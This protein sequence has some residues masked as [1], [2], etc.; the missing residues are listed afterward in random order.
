MIDPIRSIVPLPGLPGGLPELE[1]LF[2]RDNMLESGRAL[3]REAFTTDPKRRVGGGSRN[4]RVR[5]AS[6]KMGCVIQCESR[7]VER[8]FV[9]LCEHDP[10]IRLYL[11]QPIV[12]QIRTLPSE[13][14]ARTFY[15][16]LDY[17][18]YHEDHG[19]ML[20]ECKPEKKLE[21]QAR[22]VRDGD[23]WRYPALERAVAD[24]GL[25]VWVYSSEE[26]NSVWL[27]NVGWLADYVGADCPDRAL[28]DQL[29][30]RVRKVRSIRVSM[31]LELLGD[32]TEALWWLVANNHLAGDLESEL[33]HDRDWAWVHD[34]P[35]RAIAWR[36]ARTESDLARASLASRPNVVR[37]EPDARLIWD[38]VPWRVLNR[39][40]DKVTLQREDSTD[41]VVLLRIADV[42][43]LL[44]RGALHAQDEDRLDAIR[45]AREARVLRASPRELRA[46]RTRYEAFAHFKR[47]GEPPTGVSSKSIQ[48]YADS[49][50]R[51]RRL[52]LSAFVGLISQRGRPR[53]IDRLAPALRAAI[54][55]AVDAYRNDPG[56]GSKTAAYATLVDKWSHPYLEAPS[57]DTL[58]RAI[59]AIPRSELARGRRGRREVIRLEGPAPALDY[60]TPPHGDRVWAVGEIDHTPLD[61][62]LVSSVTGAVLG[63]AYLSVLIDAFTRMPLAFVLRFGAPRRYPVLELLHECV[64]RHGRVPDNIV[65][66]GGPEFSSN[67]VE[68]AFAVLEI[69]KIERAT[70]R[71]KQGAVIE[72]M[73]GIANE[74]MT[75]QL[76]GNTEPNTLGRGLSASHRPSR[77]A[78]WTL[79]KACQACEKFFFETCP[80]LQ[81]GSLGTTPRE[82]FEH[83][84]AVAGERVAKHVFFDLALRAL[85]A[86]TPKTGGPTRKVDGSRG[87]F[88]EY[89]SYWHPLFNRRDVDGISVDVKVFPDDCG[90][91]LAVVHGELRRCQLSDGGYDFAGRSRRQIEMAVAVL[92][93]QHR[94]GRSRAAR[95]ANAEIIGAFLSHLGDTEAE[96]AIKVQNLRDQENAIA[97]ASAPLAPD[98]PQLRLAAVDGK[99]VGSS[100][101]VVHPSERSASQP[102]S[103]ELPE[104]I[105]F[106]GLEA[107][108]ED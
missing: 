101:V 7:T 90:E 98:A 30:E 44:K 23:S 81:H 1:A 5:F 19:W 57:Y 34:T 40:A 16:T 95:R 88:V 43:T 108:D 26:I 21:K 97:A 37:I 106:D 51:G 69:S 13:G 64:R 27:R 84:M 105:D 68:M 62:S 87:V 86:E 17:I 54:D 73:F 78:A 47:T 4:T 31:L 33:I 91:V 22:F 46:A 48:R 76:R 71:P 75:H 18:V 74:R 60:A 39:G 24:L 70:G 50:E 41:K 45:A 53:G 96:C 66:D 83:S 107:L 29:L 72:R 52:Y 77:F 93:E 67:D 8:A 14:S 11:C 80:A 6:R 58:R 61:L 38:G 49:A 12:V 28:C 102:P 65:V 92:R 56:A 63:T 32:R 89:L 42:H 55:K 99:P 2:D 25:K 100:D 35:E 85:L 3:V 36:T 9:G 103:G 20:V 15:V 82:A 94:I 59:N 79:Q 104:C 10:K